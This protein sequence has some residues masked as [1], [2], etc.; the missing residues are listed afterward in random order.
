MA[1]K[2]KVSS[3]NG[4]RGIG[5]TSALLVILPRPPLKWRGVASEMRSGVCIAK[6]FEAALLRGDG[7]RSS[8]RPLTSVAQPLSTPHTVGETIGKIR[9]G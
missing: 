9:E 5:D 8:T 2:F 4:K 3:S 6:T 7:A 1:E